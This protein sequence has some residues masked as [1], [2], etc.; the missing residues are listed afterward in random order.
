MKGYNIFPD[1][2]DVRVTAKRRLWAP[3]P[4]TITS[5]T[6]RLSTVAFDVMSK[7]TGVSSMLI[8]KSNGNLCCSLRAFSSTRNLVSLPSNCAGSFCW[9]DVCR[10]RVNECLVINLASHPSDA[11]KEGLDGW[12]ITLACRWIVF[13][14]T[15]LCRS[16]ISKTHWQSC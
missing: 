5:L 16:L 15:G 1:A 2:V 9:I 10:R 8:I 11:S 6:P 13:H 3:V 4:H 14:C 12:I 7:H